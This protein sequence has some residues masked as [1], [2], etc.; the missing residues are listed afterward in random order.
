MKWNNFSLVGWALA[1]FIHFTLLVHCGKGLWRPANAPRPSIP[2]ACSIAA[3]AL[4]SHYHSIEWLLAFIPQQTP[5]T[6]FC[7]VHYWLICSFILLSPINHNSPPPLV[8]SFFIKERKG[9]NDEEKAIPLLERRSFAAEERQLIT[10]QFIPFHWRALHFLFLNRSLLGPLLVNSPFLSSS[11]P[12]GRARMKRKKESWMSWAPCW[13]KDE[14]NQ[15]H[16]NQNINFYLLLSL[17]SSF[18]PYCYNIFL[19]RSP[20]HETKRKF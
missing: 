9:K 19:F 11:R 18:Q 4:Q 1:P 5:F 13:K 15:L 7:F 3:P 6:F 2:F 16:K 10:H 17:S 20:T 8:F 14:F 12:L